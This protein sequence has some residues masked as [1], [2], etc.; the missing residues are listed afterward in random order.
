MTDSSSIDVSVL[1]TPSLPV[2]PGDTAFSCL[3][4][5]KMSA[6]SS[7]NVSTVTMSPHAGT[8]ADTPLHVT[9]NG[10]GSESL[11]LDAFNGPATVIDVTGSSGD[12]E[13]DDIVRLTHGRPFSRL[14]LKTGRT[15]ADGVFPDSWA[16]LSASCASE[17]VQRGLVLLGVDAPSIDERESKTLD[18]HHAILDRGGS[19]LENLDLRSV[20]PGDYLLEALP[21]KIAG[22]DAA[23]VRAL[24]TPLR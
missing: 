15:V 6:G 5:W 3:W 11:G 20:R 16:R 18:V 4:N 7:V 9:E 13:L 17:L 14:I 21:I 23:P 1:V 19:V 2:W 12:L 8:H 22:L 10:A 24:L